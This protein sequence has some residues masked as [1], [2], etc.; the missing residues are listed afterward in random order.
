MKKVIFNIMALLPTLAFA[1][2]APAVNGSFTVQGKIGTVTTPA[3]V[4]LMYQ[5]GANKVIDS[6]LIVDGHFIITGSLPNPSNSLLVLDHKGVG[7]AKLGNAPDMLEFVLDK[8]TTT[9]ST[10]KDSIKYGTI[11]G[12]TLNDEDKYLTQQITAI[13]DEAKK[14]NDEIKAQPSAKQ[15][16]PEYQ[17]QMQARFKVLQDK[18]HAMLKEFA[19]SHPHSYET[20]MVLNLMTRQGASP[21]EVNQ[22]F[23]T[24]DEPLKEMEVGKIIRKTIDDAMVTAIGSVAPDFTQPDVNG[25]PV[26]LSSLRG[27]YV[28]ID[29]WASWCGPCRA[30]NPNVVKAYN[31][32]KVKNFTIIGV[33]LDRPNE[34]DKWQAAIQHDGLSWT[35]VSDLKAWYNDAAALYKVQA[36]PANFLLDPSGK[37]IAKD[38][39]GADLEHKLEEL[40]GKI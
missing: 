25:T 14:L 13:N 23:G 37:I 8:G 38:L 24:L 28:L 11:T 4:Y 1:Q 20:L 30:E 16:S 27:K 3:W 6:T 21:I 2:T 12:S 19:V 26:K 18:Q 36:I 10:E 5:A 32:Y 17:E 15:N 7:I 9:L 22:L 31:K 35:Q 39:R 29:F 40:F 34:K 33:S